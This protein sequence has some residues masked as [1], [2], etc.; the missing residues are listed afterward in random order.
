MGAFVGEAWVDGAL[1]DGPLW[2]WAL[3]GWALWGWGL[4]WMGP[5]G[6]GGL[7][8]WGPLGMGAFVDGALAVILRSVCLSPRSALSSFSLPTRSAG[9]PAT[10]PVGTLH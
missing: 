6:D 3:W 5:F 10:S 1:W 2:G 7:G 4:G 8:G 9:P